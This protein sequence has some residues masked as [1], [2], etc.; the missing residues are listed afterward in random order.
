MKYFIKRDL[1]EYGPY[2]LADLQRYVAQGNISPNDLTRGEGMTDWVPVSQIVGSI[3]PPAP[4]APVPSASPQGTVYGGAPTSAAPAAT[5]VAPA[6]VQAYG[7]PVGQVVPGIVPPD[8]HW[9]LV[10]LIGLFCGLFVLVWLFIEAA[11][12]KKIR[13]QSNHIAVIIAGFAIQIGSAMVFY[14]ALFSLAATSRSSEPPVGPLAALGVFL[15][16]GIV[17]GAVVHIVG[18][19]KMRAAMVE[20]YNTVEPINLRMSGVGSAL[21]TIFFPAYYFQWHF[22]R[23]A[24]WKR[25]GY[26]E[27]QV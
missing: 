4:P 26:L 20:Y 5:A 9:A 2:T 1:N 12:V 27:P 6:G 3:P 15:F 22:S 10:L 8:F 21:L 17:G 24:A 11:F 13:P 16:L 7:A 23:I 19:F 25:T 18:T 14:V